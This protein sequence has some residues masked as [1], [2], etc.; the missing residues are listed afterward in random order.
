MTLHSWMKMNWGPSSLPKQ[1]ASTNQWWPNSNDSLTLKF[2]ST[3]HSIP[4]K[5]KTKNYSKM[6]NHLLLLMPRKP[7]LQNGPRNLVNWIKQPLEHYRQ[8]FGAVAGR[9]TL[10]LRGYGDPSGRGEAF[11]FVKAPGEKGTSSAVANSAG[12]EYRQDISRIWESH[13]N[14]LSGGVVGTGVV[15]TS[16]TGVSTVVSTNTTPL[17]FLL[18][19]LMALNW[20]SQIWIR[21]MD[22]W[23]NHRSFN[24]SRL[25]ENQKTSFR[26]Y[27][28][29]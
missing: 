25:L 22:H 17:L 4:P 18:N 10:K 29:W 2:S 3:I 24:H 23:R 21:S 7:R 6:T 5:L 19:S 12:S 28:C 26:F 16:N 11:S 27:F 15:I 20:S 1:F 8:L 9:C 14:S 13:I